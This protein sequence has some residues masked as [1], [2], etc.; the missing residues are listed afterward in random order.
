MDR[1][2]YVIG[3]RLAK[4]QFKGPRNPSVDLTL[5]HLLFQPYGPSWLTGAHC[6]C[7]VGEFDS[8]RRG[9]L[10]AD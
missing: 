6:Q 7:D 2:T 3:K 10:R 1:M 5:V 4:S 8:R 9:Q